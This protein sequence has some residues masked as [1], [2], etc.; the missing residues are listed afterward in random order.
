[1]FVNNENEWVVFNAIDSNVPSLNNKGGLTA[2]PPRDGWQF[3]NKGS[4]RWDDDS[5]LRVDPPS[6][7]VF[8]VHG[9]N[10]DKN[11]SEIGYT[12][13][14]DQLNEGSW[15]GEETSIFGLIQR[16]GLSA[17]QMMHGPK[18]LGAMFNDAGYA[19]FPSRDQP[20]PGNDSYFNGGYTLG[21]HG[22]RKSKGSNG[23]PIDALQV[24][25]PSELRRPKINAQSIRDR[26]FL[27]VAQIFQR[28][29]VQFYDN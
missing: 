11:A 3:W 8:D 22:S 2:T 18:S 10:H 21:V 12:L 15:T 7:L 23:G 13:N 9:H 27:D 19:A 24:E 29:Y 25:F 1:M 28:F 6:A 4:S 17:A 14:S 5:K 26:L 20:T 16:S